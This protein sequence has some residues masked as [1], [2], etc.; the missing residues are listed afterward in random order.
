M[1]CFLQS[2]PSKGVLHTVIT[3][4]KEQ[5]Q[6]SH[7]YDTIINTRKTRGAWVA[8]LVKHGTL[9]FHSGHNLTV[10]TL[11][12]TSP[13]F[14]H[15]EHG[16]CFRFSLSLSLCFSPACTLS[17]KT[18]Q[19]Q[20]NKNPKPRESSPLWVEQLEK[21]TCASGLSLQGLNEASTH[22]IFN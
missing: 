5:H 12:P 15:A 4:G 19:K 8:Q 17:Q 11:S 10:V 13:G 7:T 21:P 16:A 1:S 14:L 2:T 3:W 6:H 20:A 18:K 22:P 9:D